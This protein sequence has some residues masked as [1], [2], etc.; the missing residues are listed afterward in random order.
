M[1]QREP[2]LNIIPASGAGRDWCKEED[3]K[4]TRAGWICG[5]AGGCLVIPAAGNAR[6][7]VEEPELPVGWAA[8]L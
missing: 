8:R 3:C 5:S 7:A 6:L 1:L 4:E 2:E